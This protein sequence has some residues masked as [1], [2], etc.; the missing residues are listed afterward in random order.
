MMN[1]INKKKIW[2]K[3]GKVVNMIISK[4]VYPLKKQSF[5]LKM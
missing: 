5:V 1:M 4:V 2:K 3:T